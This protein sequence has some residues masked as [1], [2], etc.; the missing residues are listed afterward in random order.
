MKLFITYPNTNLP[1]SI[2]QKALNI[3]PR[4]K[5]TYNVEYKCRINEKVNLKVFKRNKQLIMNH[6]FYNSLNIPS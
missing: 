1:N 4:A 6:N 5:I 3:P 2:S